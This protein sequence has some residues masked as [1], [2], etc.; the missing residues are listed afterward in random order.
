[1]GE[2]KASKREAG[3]KGGRTVVERYGR[4]HMCELGH[5]GGEQVYAR[6]GEEHMAR[7]GVRG[8]WTRHKEI[9]AQ[10]RQ[11]AREQ[12]HRNTDWISEALGLDIDVFPVNG[13]GG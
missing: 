13:D 12:A 7:I 1:M 6:H 10:R 11:A 9:E 2:N 4:E 5:K 3:S 8:G